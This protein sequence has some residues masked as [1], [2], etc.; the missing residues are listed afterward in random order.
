METQENIANF[1]V[2]VLIVLFCAVLVCMVAYNFFSVE[3]KG[4]L[5]NGIL[6]LLS[7]V[8]IL[9]LAESFDNFSIGKLISISREAKKKEEKV[10]ELEHKNSELIKQVI[11][12]STAQNQT[13]QH[14]NVYGDYHESLSDEKAS[15]QEVEKKSNK[16]EVEKLLALAGDS[17]LISDRV[18]SI[19][20]DL[21]EKGLSTEGDTVRVLTRHLAAT[22]LLV[23]FEKVHSVIFGS[24]IYL[25]KKLN[26]SIDEGRSFEVVHAHI[27]AVKNSFSDQL[28]DWSYEQYLAYLYSNILIVDGENEKLHITN[29]GVE[30]LTWIIRNG[31]NENKSL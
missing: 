17:L 25:L 16:E 6:V 22:Q 10:K 4:E 7:M 18:S 12:I 2:R 20:S 13:Q 8:L 24:Q 31:R 15:S 5:N 29:L 28:S 3:P 11:S 27:D 21:R 9:V 14:T 26:E 19:E 30:Y 1:F 23:T